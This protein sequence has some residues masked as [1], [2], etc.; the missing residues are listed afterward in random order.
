MLE[1]IN[2]KDEL[3]RGSLILVIMFGLFN[4]LNYIF[5]ISM[6]N[7][8]EL[9]DYGIL[10]ALMSIVYI[11]GIP[12][13]AIQI[14]ISKYTSKFNIK[15]QNGKIKDLLLRSIK[16]ALILSSIFFII[17]LILGVFISLWLRI[18]FFLIALTGIAIFGT[19]LLPI[20][21]GILQ[22]KK[23]FKDMGLNMVLESIFKIILSVMLVLL[24]LRVYGAMGAL[25]MAFA[26]AFFLSLLAIKDVLLSKRENENFEGIYSYNLPNLIAITAIVLM[27]SLDILLARR[28]FS[29]ELAGQYAFV[30]LIGKAIVFINIA[31]GKVMFPLASEKYENGTETKGILKKSIIF[32]MIIS[33][34]A[35][36]FYTLF[37]EFVVKV[38]S[39]GSTKYLAASGI[40]GILGLA[41][42]FTSI[43]N[44]LVLHNLSLNKMK[45]SA[46][47][48]II[49][50]VI[51]VVLLSIFNSNIMEFSISLALSNFLM[52]LYNLMLL[53]K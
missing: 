35:L 20:T 39:L 38:I 47:F 8:L 17:F 6:A 28:F 12:S 36:F 7:M 14:V 34:I 49:F 51:E 13:E 23:K 30:S 32:V 46:F 42:T 9:A 40:L 29:A 16:K 33:I 19:F 43:S 41:F 11:F 15:N 2:F 52:L 53:K 45:K 21:R 50:P 24:G 31:I 44:I 5:Q 3:L 18:N 48:L 26:I 22:G 4:L 27:Y 37:P 10:A 25:I 1:K